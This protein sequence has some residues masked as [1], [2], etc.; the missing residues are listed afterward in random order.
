MVVLVMHP[1]AGKETQRVILSPLENKLFLI[2][3]H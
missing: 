2:I 1:N 3:I